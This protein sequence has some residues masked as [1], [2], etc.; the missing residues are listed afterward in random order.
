MT[1]ELIDK[2][3]YAKGTRGVVITEVQAG[4]S[5]AE[6]GLVAGMLVTQV[7]RRDVTTVAQFIAAMRA[8]DAASGVRLRVADSE[9][10]RRFVFITPQK[11]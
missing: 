4:S 8:K 10:G 2:Y 1:D 5:A 11:K 9:G 6:Q 7:Q 3:G